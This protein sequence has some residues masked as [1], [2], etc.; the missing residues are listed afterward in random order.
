MSVQVWSLGE[1]VSAPLVICRSADAEALRNVITTGGV[2]VSAFHLSPNGEPYLDLLRCFLA[3]RQDAEWKP[4]S[5]SFVTP[6]TAWITR[7]F[8]RLASG[9]SE[10]DESAAIAAIDQ[11]LM[12]ESSLHPQQA[13][14]VRFCEDLAKKL[15]RR[16]LWGSP[17][18][19]SWPPAANTRNWWQLS[20]DLSTE[21]NSLRTELANCFHGTIPTVLHGLSLRLNR[22]HGRVTSNLFG[23]NRESAMLEASALCAALATVHYSRSRYSLATLLCHRAADLLFTSICAS[24]NLIDFTKASGDGELRTSIAG[25]TDLT[26]LNCHDALQQASKILFDTVRRK[27]LSDL[28]LTR[29]RLILTHGL[30][31]TSG[32]ETASR[33]KSVVT[34]LKLQGGSAWTTAYEE[35]RMGFSLKPQDFFELCDGLMQTLTPV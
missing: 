25:R 11:L 34:L 26:L 6:D 28:N 15:I 8:M 23:T 16:M 4:N 21:I 17:L 3:L 10:W 1:A 33:L 18:L 12:H 5:S 22:L 13:R 2:S 19:L 20:G 7:N 9:L 30:G 35:Y 27:S 24:Q 14:F 31:S 29:N 32:V